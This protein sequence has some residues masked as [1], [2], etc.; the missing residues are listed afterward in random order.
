MENKKKLFLIDAYSIIYR[1]YFAFIRNPRYNSKGL[2]TSSI[3]GFVNVIIDIVKNGQPDYLAVAFDL[4][5]LT[6]R[7]QLYSDYKANRQETPEDIRK[8]I[9]YIRE[10]LEKFQIRVFEKQGFEADDI[11]GTLSKMAENE[12]FEVFMVTPDKDYCQLVTDAVKIFKPK[13]SGGEY[14]VLGK[15]EI[16]KRFE[17]QS[18]EQFIDILALMGDSSDN[19]PGAP[20]VG[21]KTAIKLIGEFH[22]LDNIYQHLDHLKGKV[23]E[24]L[25][26]YKEQVYLSKKLAA[27]KTDIPLEVNWELLKT[28]NPVKQQLLPL[29]EELEFKSIIKRLFDENQVAA[30]PYQTSLFDTPENGSQPTETTFDD[31]QS[32]PHHYQLVEDEKMLQ[33]LIVDIKNTGYCCVDTETTSLDIFNASLVGISIAVQPHEAFFIPVMHGKIDPVIDKIRPVLEDKQI[34]KIGQNIKFDYQVLK[35]HGIDM[36]GFEFDTMIA[37]YLLQPE[38]KHNLDF[39]AET[40]LQYRKITTESLIGP[41]GKLQSSMDTVPVSLI[42]DYACEDADITLQ[43]YHYFRDEFKDKKPAYLLYQVEMPLIEVLAGMELNGVM[44]DSI[45]LHEYAVVL[46][47]EIIEIEEKIYQMAG[48]SF[49]V[50]SPKQL[51]EVL[52]DHLKIDK[53]AELTKTKQYSTSEETLEKLSGKHP[54]IELILE[55]RGLKKLLNTYVEAL[56]KLIKP[57]T[58]RLHTSFNQTKTST[59]R[60]SS[61]N[62]N[63]QNIPIRDEKGREMRKAFIPEDGFYLLSADYSQIE[64]RLMAHM[65]SDTS[66]IEAFNNGRDIHAETASKIFKVAPE[67]VSKDMRRKA[68]TANFGIIY[69]ISSFGLSQRLKISR[70]EAKELIDGYFLNFPAVKAY[71]DASI[72]KARQQGFVETLFG[73]RRYLPDINSKNANVRGLAERNAINAPIQGSAAD[74]IKIAM[75]SIF[76]EMKKRRMKSRMLLQVHDELVFE[77]EKSELDELISLVKDKMEKAANLKVPLI[78]DTGYGNNWL[79]AH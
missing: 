36:Q 47:K 15:E 4:G 74:I 10:M 45:A 7:H 31:I 73:R 26:A 68:K 63:L 29:F 33:Q 75:V 16:Q 41:K 20:G 42:K 52:F 69:G 2:N 57:K 48:F 59:G 17:I 65:S 12:G 50:S 72:L 34:R 39:L 27:I 56:P 1:S 58:G 46:R 53:P 77:A 22:S 19:I 30:Q 49:N 38:L 54:V 78:A 14:E 28:R 70:T 11:I 18:P 3:Y 32:V 76:N 6:F 62:P 51:G 21:E 55:Y 40:C 60:L 5:G 64:L 24:T 23:K 35:Q 43:L 13:S 37:H 25:S 8:S 66:M 44:I 67:E 79:E 9:P 71:M 61:T